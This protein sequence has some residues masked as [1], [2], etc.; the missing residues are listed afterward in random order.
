MVV[1]IS[2]SSSVINWSIKNKKIHDNWGLYGV[3]VAEVEVAV[4]GVV[5]SK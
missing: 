1:V 2:C 4:V 5:V 3:A